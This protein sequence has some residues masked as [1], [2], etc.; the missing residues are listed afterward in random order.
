MSLIRHPKE[1][2]GETNHR[3][4]FFLA[5]S[6]PRAPSLHHSFPSPFMPPVATDA[7]GFATLALPLPLHVP[8]N[9][10]TLYTQALV[11]DPHGSFGTWA[12]TQGLGFRLGL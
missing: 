11:S 10:I 8:F 3:P 6:L 7:S 9:G 4:K 2:G 5:A 1:R 12:C